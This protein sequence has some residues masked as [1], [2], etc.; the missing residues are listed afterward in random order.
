MNNWTRRALLPTITDNKEGGKGEA[1]GKVKQASAHKQ[2][3]K[4]GR[5]EGRQRN[6]E[7][8]TDPSDHSRTPTPREAIPIPSR[9]FP[10]TQKM[11]PIHQLKEGS[12]KVGR[13]KEER[14]TP[15]LRKGRKE[16]RPPAPVHRPKISSG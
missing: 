1:V 14:Q 11:E 15:T 9:L 6:R 2:A 12:S 4:Q 3:R 13:K 16:R 8:G 10:P 5:K 7:E